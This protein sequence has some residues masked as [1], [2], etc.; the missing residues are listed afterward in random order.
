[1][2]QGD[3]RGTPNSHLSVTAAVAAAAAAAHPAFGHPRWC[4]RAATAAATRVPASAAA[5][6][7]ASGVSAAATSGVS[8][9]AAAA[10]AAAATVAR[11]KARARLVS[12]HAAGA[13]AGEPIDRRPRGGFSWGGEGGEGERTAHREENTRVEGA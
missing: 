12:R 5:A 7:A 10:A 13:I 1:M 6:A 8:A 11:G 4:R 2:L 9:A 3:V